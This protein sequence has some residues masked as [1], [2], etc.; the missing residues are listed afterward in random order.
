MLRYIGKEMLDFLCGGSSVPKRVGDSSVM[1]WAVQ[2]SV[3]LYMAVQ[4]FIFHDNVLLNLNEF[5]PID[6][7]LSGF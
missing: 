6:H 3:L 1:A 5:L 2:Y 7:L 4:L